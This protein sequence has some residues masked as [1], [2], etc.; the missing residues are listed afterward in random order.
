MKTT[1]LFSL[2]IFS[3]FLVSSVSALV[4]YGDWQ[5]SSQDIQIVEGQ[6]INFNVDFVSVSPPIKIQIELYN[7]ESNLVVHY[8]EKDL[9]IKGT[10]YFSN[11]TLSPSIYKNPGQYQII[12]TGTDSINSYTHVL[13]LKIAKSQ[14]DTNPPVITLFGDNPVTI[15][16]GT[17]YVDAGATAWDNEDGDLTSEIVVTGSVN[18]NVVGTY[19]LTYS[20]QDSS[21]NSAQIIRTINVISSGS[22]TNPP[23][24]TLLGDAIVNIKLGATYVDAGAT[25][26]D[27]E[28]GDLTSQIQV[29]GT[30]N[31]NVVGTYVLAYNVK[32]CAGN[33]APTVIRTVNVFKPGDTSAP[34]IIV[35]SPENKEYT[36][37][38]INF[39]IK[40]SETSDVRFDLDNQGK[41]IMNY[42]G[43]YAGFLIFKNELCLADGN[44]KVIFYA[45]D[46]SGNMATKSVSFSVHI[47]QGGGNNETN[48]EQGYTSPT[49]LTN[50]QEEQLYFEQFQHPKIIYI[51]EEKPKHLNFWQRLIAWLK[52]FFGFE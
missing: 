30:V 43:I 6:S 49:P 42:Q 8:F 21:G 51:E 36:Q 28:D 50:A 44:H 15:V 10:S 32:D 4:V 31:T 48:E 26:Y 20:V 52:R 22:D 17:H 34:I 18:T 47:S 12:L 2:L 33:S 3:I 40:V 35:I 7:P 14:Q 19:L 41:R 13:D 27:K 9:E 25:A 16:Q 37:S 24:I 5:D 23:V 1:K 11:Y 29:T 45:T 38:K 46:S 39:E